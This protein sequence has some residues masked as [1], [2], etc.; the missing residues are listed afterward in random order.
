MEVKKLALYYGITREVIG[1]RQCLHDWKE[2]DEINTDGAKTVIYAVFDNTRHN[3][4]VITALF[5]ILNTNTAMWCISKYFDANDPDDV[6]DLEF[7]DFFDWISVMV[8]T[9]QTMKKR[10]WK[11]Y[12]NRLDFMEAM[13]N[14]NLH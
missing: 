2:G 4:A 14:N 5:K 11:N 8:C 1:V 13:V 12:E 10:V 7:T 6:D 9:Q 3:L